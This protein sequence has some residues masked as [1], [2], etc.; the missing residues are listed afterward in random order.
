MDQPKMTPE[1]ENL[2]INTI[3]MLAVDAVEK[4]QS[5]HPGTPM[6]AAPMAFELWM[7]HMKYN[8]KNPDW[9]NRDRFVLS[10]GHASMLLYSML[11]LTGFDLP[12]DQIKQFR[13]FGSKTPG[14]PEYGHTAGVETT[15]GPLGQGISTSVGMAIANKFLAETFNRPG[16]E[17]I[18]YWIYGY[19]S[20]GDLMEGVASEASS[21]A[22]H[23]KLGRMIF[24]YS[25]NHITIDG[26]T[27]ITFTEDVGKRYEAYGWFVQ[28]IEGNDR[29]AFNAAVEKCKKPSL[30]SCAEP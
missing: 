15:T 19:C 3:R 29:T 26:S 17:I 4:A 5:G 28:H 10:A 6:E 16:H 8:P 11:H 12:L 13:Q 7:R 2:C 9:F 21:I 18:D 23:L 25:D 14:H 22:G 27:E 20:D 30:L 1:L 24:V